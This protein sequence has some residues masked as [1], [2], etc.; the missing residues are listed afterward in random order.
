VPSRVVLD[1]NVYISAYGFG[2]LPAR[3]MRPAIMGG[4]ELVTSPALLAEVARVLADKLEFDSERVEAAVMQIARIAAVVR[5][6]QRLSVV[7]DEPDNRVLECAVCGG[8]DT[9]VSGDR[10]LLELGEYAGIRIVSVAQVV[11]GLSKT[12]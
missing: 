5:P 6:T 10:H 12:R 3:L 9:I 7:A 8:A 2:G 1:T 11:E 4:F